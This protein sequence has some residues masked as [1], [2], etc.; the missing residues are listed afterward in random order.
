MNKSIRNSK[1]L[2]GFF[3][4]CEKR[5]TALLA[6]SAV[7][8]LVQGP[9]VAQSQSVAAQSKR[10]DA[11]KSTQPAPAAKPVQV[12]L[13]KQPTLYVVSYA[14]LDTQWR[15]EYPQ[16][17]RE[18]LT[19]T[20]RDNFALFEKYPHY[21]FNFSGAN[22]YRLIK[23]YFPADY[24]KLKQYVAA[25]RWFPAGS[26][27]EESDV[28]SPS[29]ESIIRQVLYGNQ[30][31]R[32]EFGKTSAEYM[33]PDCFGFPASLPSILAHMGLKGFSTQKLTWGSAAPVGGP[34]SPQDTPPGIPFNVGVWEGP[35]GRSVIAAFNPG[36]Y[37]SRIYSDLSK[38]NTPPPNPAQRDYVWDWPKRIELNG[39]GSGVFA[40]YHYVGTGDTGGS[41]TEDSVRMMNAIVA[42]SVTSIPPA[43]LRA[44]AGQVGQQPPAPQASA[45]V[46]VGDGPLRVVSAA[47]D[48]L[49]R[50]IR[51]EQMA[52]LPRYMGD[53]ELTN[54]SA[55]S[56]TSQTYQKRW[57]R[58]NELLADAA[59]RASVAAAWLGG[60]T[61]PLERL[62]NAWTLVMGGQFHDIQ[63][64]TSTPKAYQF[65]WNDDVI[66]MNQFAGVLTSATQAI[67]SALDTRTAGAAVVVYNPLNI[68]REDVV[69]ATVSFPDGEWK[70]V[71]VVGP[72]GNEVELYVVCGPLPDLEAGV[73]HFNPADFSLRRLRSGD[74]RGLLARATANE[75]SIVEA[76]VT[77]VCTGT[78]WRNA[79][80]YQARTYRHFFW[81]N[82][83]MLANL[84]ATA[85]AL[86]VPAHLAMG[87]VDDDVNRL[88]GLDTQREV[89]ISLVPLG[90]ESGLAAEVSEPLS[91]LK[92]RVAPCSKS[93]V[94]YPLMR[95]AHEASSLP[96]PEEVKE[97]RALSPIFLISAAA[98]PLD[99]ALEMEE[100]LEA[101]EAEG[102]TA[103]S[104][105]IVAKR[106]KKGSINQVIELKAPPKTDS[107]RESI[108]QVIVRRGSSRQFARL[109]IQFEQ[110]STIL[111]RATQ[112]IPADFLE[113][114]GT[115]LND[116][117]LIVN[118]VEG[119]PSGAYFLRRDRACLE[120]LKVGSFRREA[121]HLG[122]DQDLPADASI[123][124]FF[125]AD[126]KKTLEVFG[127]RGYRA[128]QIEAGIIGGKI[129]LGAYAQ[130]LGA[131]GLTFYD[132]EVT[133]FFSPHAKGKSAIFLTAVGLRA[134]SQLRV[135]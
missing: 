21:V 13:T 38:A 120:L 73:Y 67:A 126:L 14:H 99:E 44:P 123:A 34:G 6:L 104:T 64:G 29:A 106:E 115:R 49:F 77:M 102:G 112:G 23:E 89:V 20:M 15:W 61:Y 46:K 79:W 131:T 18:Y 85:A 71:R 7:F 19:K 91:A 2:G 100:A 33:L 84:F 30:F 63:P 17:I 52:R 53:L 60:R 37:G 90:K 45:P 74:W 78:Y 103:R 25:G 28:N 72:D 116:L 119:L 51:P 129:Y 4:R 109:P 96:S 97:W 66:A 3:S 80:K 42:K 27:M 76:P 69:E 125:L 11:E 36:S 16:T 107:P 54:H 132:D 70:S 43:P 113:P 1:F 121:G 65:S 93:E 32:R 62:N 83:T 55:G 75:P 68:A 41:P 130:G 88:L 22:R 24:A 117:Y 87:F 5:A 10:A 134:K 48:Q 105:P 101:W 94:D 127:N 111:V 128:A 82:G 135:L 31:F 50:D 40:D 86:R 59:E 39:K 35:D 95:Q 133:E 58:K 122:L 12:D 124:I 81:D 92:Y 98:G 108:E 56:L 9:A 26:S 118:A 110:L 47:A 8:F 114:F 57:N